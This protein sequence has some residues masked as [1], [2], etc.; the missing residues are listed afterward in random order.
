M[1]AGLVSLVNIVKEKV[2]FMELLQKYVGRSWK[3]FHFRQKQANYLRDS[4]EA[5]KLC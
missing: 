4:M 2:S 1:P 5:L 3:I